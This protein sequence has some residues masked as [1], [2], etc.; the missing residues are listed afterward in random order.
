MAMTCSSWMMMARNCCKG[1]MQRL[2][3]LLAAGKEQLALALMVS[4]G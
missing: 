3:L 4:G 2:L 1:S